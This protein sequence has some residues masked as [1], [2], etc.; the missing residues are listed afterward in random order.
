MDP[1]PITYTELL[2]QLLAKQLVALSCVLPLK[3]PFPKSYN[4]NVH[5]DYHVGNPGHSMEDC[6]SLKQQVQT[7]I[8]VGKINFKNS[9]QPS[10][11]LLNFSRA[12]TE[13]VEKFATTSGRI[14]GRKTGYTT[15]KT[16]EEKK[17]SDRKSVV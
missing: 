8:K 6:L 13:E 14:Q 12:R 1:I 3:P 15:E 9:N 2:P 11:L 17:P 4:P 16:E 7:L 5:C 10:N